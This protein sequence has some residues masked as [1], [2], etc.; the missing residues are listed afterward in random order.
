MISATIRTLGHLALWPTLYAVGVLVLTDWF[1]TNTTPQWAAV[2]FVAFCAHGCYL[3]DRVKISDTRLDPADQLAQPTRY[4]FLISHAR[5]MRL[6]IL[7]DLALATI[8]AAIFAPVL[9]WIPAT[10]LWCVHLY[11]GRASDVTNPRLKDFPAIKAFFIAGGHGALALAATLGEHGFHTH[12][13]P[14]AA[15]ISLIGIGAIVFGDAVL[16]DL[17]D[18]DTDQQFATKSL[19]VLFGS[20]GAWWI[21]IAAHALGVMVIGALNG[22][23]LGLGVFGSVLLMTDGLF[24]IFPRQRDAVDARLLPLVILLVVI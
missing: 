5:I 16:C 18:H 21:A 13:I 23:V 10:A 6:M 22:W 1:F 2:C 4:Q 9:A 24:R 14:L 19:P 7:A 17:D 15:W 11:A 12:Q 20:N 3:L 8:A